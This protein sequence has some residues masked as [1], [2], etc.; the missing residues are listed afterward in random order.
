M[1]NGHP[2]SPLFFSGWKAPP[3]T[4]GAHA[5]QLWLIEGGESSLGRLGRRGGGGRR[6]EG[7]EVEE[8]DGVTTLAPGEPDGGRRAARVPGIEPAH[9]AA[10]RVVPHAVGIRRA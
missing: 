5:S 7:V 9:D 6:L 10:L 2:I 3:K 1:N 8:V 4:R